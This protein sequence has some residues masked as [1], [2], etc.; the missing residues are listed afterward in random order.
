MWQV[1]APSV[2]GGSIVGGSA[3][4]GGRQWPSMVGRI[5]AECGKDQEEVLE[6]KW[7]EKPGSR[8]ENKRARSVT[9][10]A[11]D[12]ATT[13][14]NGPALSSPDSFFYFMSV[15]LIVI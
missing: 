3:E 15:Y 8:A 4:R 14:T 1:G 13:P 9:S 12:G 7:P 5:S 2:A 10:A 6:E 11:I